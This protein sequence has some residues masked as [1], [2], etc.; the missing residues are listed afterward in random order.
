MA[1]A[2]TYL[3]QVGKFVLGGSHIGTGGGRYRMGQSPL[4]TRAT[5]QGLDDES[6]V[7]DEATL[8]PPGPL[9]VPRGC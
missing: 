5:R 7:T 3:E 6:L 4:G 2:I 9:F 8:H 1:A